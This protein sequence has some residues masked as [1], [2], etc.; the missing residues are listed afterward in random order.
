M[1]FLALIVFLIVAFCGVYIV[2]RRKSNKKANRFLVR[3]HG[4]TGV[5]GLILLI[6]GQFRGWYWS[7][8]WGW[9]SVLLFTTLL[10]FGFMVFGKWF[11]D[12][13]T[14]FILIMLHGCFASICIGV[15]TYSLIMVN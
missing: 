14:P 5:V 9:I 8:N 7:S 4:L 2:K 10:V 13:K 6:I 11:K 12:R 1:Q 3:A 15:L